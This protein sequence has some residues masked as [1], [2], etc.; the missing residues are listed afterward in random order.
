MSNLITFISKIMLLSES[1][2]M[3]F[4]LSFESRNVENKFFRIYEL[5]D[6]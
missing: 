3:E 4:D 1:H 5:A 2:R 6:F